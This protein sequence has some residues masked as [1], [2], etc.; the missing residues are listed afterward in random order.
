MVIAA[1]VLIVNPD[2]PDQ[3]LGVARKDDPNAFGLPGGKVHDNEPVSVAAKREAKE[4][5]GLD[6]S[7][8]EPL[9]SSTDDNGILCVT[10]LAKISPTAVFKPDEGEA[11][12]KW[13]SWDDLKNGPFGKYNTALF[14]VYEFEIDNK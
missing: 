8:L 13:V 3:I 1:C 2:D 9:F 4:E 6:L 10:Y 14:E 7:D 5:T 12:V 11:Q